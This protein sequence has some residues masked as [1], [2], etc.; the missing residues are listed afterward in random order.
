MW[1]INTVALYRGLT[2]INFNNFSDFCPLIF[3][4]AIFG[5]QKSLSLSGIQ[6]TECKV[7]RVRIKKA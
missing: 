6:F 5:W 1:A 2:V 4:P 3:S 7:D